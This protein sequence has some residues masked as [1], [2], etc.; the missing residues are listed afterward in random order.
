MYEYNTKKSVST[1]PY[2]IALAGLGSVDRYY[3]PSER[4][5]AY[6]GTARVFLENINCTCYHNAP[7]EEVLRASLPYTMEISLP[8][9]SFL[10]SCHPDM[11]CPPEVHEGA[12]LQDPWRI[13]RCSAWAE[14]WRQDANALISSPGFRDEMSRRVLDVA[15]ITGWRRNLVK[16]AEF[17]QVIQEREKRER[18]IKI[19]AVLTLSLGSGVLFWTW[20][21]NRK[22]AKEAMGPE[23]E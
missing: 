23:G 18:P 8:G 19:F 13:R 17:L 15:G 4:R 21:R 11:V 20:L 14:Q 10:C 22:K 5:R 7:R 9:H 6:W 12:Y 1:K 16:P 2:P 3:P